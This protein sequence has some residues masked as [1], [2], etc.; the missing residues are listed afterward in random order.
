MIR[1]TGQ[2]DKTR[3]LGAE[4]GHPELLPPLL[5]LF[6]QRQED[7]QRGGIE[8]LQFF[9]IDGDVLPTFEQRERGLA[10]IRGEENIDRALQNDGALAFSLGDAYG[11][12]SFLFHLNS[13]A[14]SR[15][16]RGGG[17]IEGAAGALDFD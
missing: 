7:L 11:S 15:S 17:G 5:Q 6:F 12:R 3:R 13:K 8:A 2:A 1:E 4:L 14:Q 16:L 9:T 10:Q